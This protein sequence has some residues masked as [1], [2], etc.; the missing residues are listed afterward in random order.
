MASGEKL[1]FATI[2]VQ[3]KNFAVT[4]NNYGFYKPFQSRKAL[5][6]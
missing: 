2:A 3:G 1:A 4:S 5:F 6:I